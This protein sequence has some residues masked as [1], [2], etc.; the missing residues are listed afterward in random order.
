MSKFPV[1]PL[2]IGHEKCAK[3]KHAS[4]FAAVFVRKKKSFMT[5]AYRDNL[6]NSF[7]FKMFMPN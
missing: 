4:L 1:F 7:P 3:Y 2:I 6:G 5:L